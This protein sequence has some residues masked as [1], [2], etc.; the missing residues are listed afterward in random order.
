MPIPV[1]AGLLALATAIAPVLVLAGCGSG[2]SSDPATAGPA[3]QAV[4]KLRDY[5]LTAEQAR[6]V[7]QEVGAQTV[8]EAADLNAFTDSQ[9]Y[10]DAAKVCVT[11]G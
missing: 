4:E 9:Q 11:D 10:R 8:V 5:G 3:K 1:R 6:C 7:V 2:S